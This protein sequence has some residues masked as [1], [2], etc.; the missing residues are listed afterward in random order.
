MISVFQICFDKKSEEQLDPAFIP[1][2]KNWQDDY[3]E[4]SVIKKVY[5]DIHHPSPISPVPSS[6]FHLS[7]YIG[8]TSWKQ[9]QKSHFSGKEII[10]R[11]EKDIAA[12]T[13]KDVY[14]YSPIQGIEPIWDLNVE[15]PELHATI[16][17]PDIWT[18]HKYR[19][20]QIETDNKLLND[21]KVLPFDLFDGK[22]Q[23]CHCN[24]WIAKR[25][26]FDEYCEKVLLPAMAFYERPKIKESMPKWYKHS[27]TGNMHNSCCFTMEG[28]FGAFLAH[29]DYSV[30]YLCRKYH[31]RRYQDIRIDGYK[32]TNDINLLT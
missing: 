3:F 1:F 5:E 25:A 22:W 28:L 14:I 17:F 16:R 20:P 23:Y 2:Y 32:V 11:I 8:I 31:R 10:D 27:H 21:A 18:M 9:Q 6:I 13:A 19:W 30:K 26:I 4:N 29:N 24:Y 15:P 12:G 7:S